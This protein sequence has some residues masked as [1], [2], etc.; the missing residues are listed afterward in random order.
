MT[1]KKD[2]QS[3]FQKLIGFRESVGYAVAT[4]KSSVPPFIDFC[5]ERFP[6]AVLITK[7]MVGVR[8]RLM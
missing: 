7:E 6:N 4:Y 3:D 2:L 1:F 8:Q 5:G